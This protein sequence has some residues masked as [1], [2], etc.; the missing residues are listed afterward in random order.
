MFYFLPFTVKDNRLIYIVSNEGTRSDNE[1]FLC[2]PKYDGPC[3]A[4]PQ[5]PKNLA[6]RAYGRYVKLTG[7]NK[8]IAFQELE[9]AADRNECTYQNPP[10]TPEH[11]IEVEQTIVLH[12]LR[13]SIVLL[14][15]PK[16]L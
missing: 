11:T 8:E 13:K 10:R 4:D 1:Q 12:H 15:T 3:R 16:G 6:L 14:H 9:E 7:F 2:L 5:I